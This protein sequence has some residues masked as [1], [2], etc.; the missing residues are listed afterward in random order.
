MF[1][2][3]RVN[4]IVP[5]GLGEKFVRKPKNRFAARAFLEIASERGPR[6]KTHSD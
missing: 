2:L 5:V 1:P 6:S 3:N 4:Y